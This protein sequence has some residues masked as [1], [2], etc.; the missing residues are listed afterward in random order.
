MPCCAQYSV[1][2]FLRSQVMVH[3]IQEIN[4]RTPR[5][6]PGLTLGYDI[7]D[8]CGDV[9]YAIRAALE[10]L[11]KEPDT[12]T[13]LLPSKFYSAMP[14]PRAKVVIGERYSEVSIAVARIFTLSSVPQISYA[15][16]SELLSKKFKFP[17]FLRTVSSDKFQTK[18]ISTMI[19]SFN[20]KTVAIIGSDDEYGKYGSDSLD[21]TLRGMQVCIE[22]VEILSGDFTRT[23]SKL[24]ELK[25]K[26]EKS[27]AEAIILFTKDANVEV[28]M[29]LAIERNLNRT[30]I[31]SDTWSTSDRI[32][33]L[34]NIQ[35]AGQVFGFIFKR[36]EVPGFKAH[37]TSM[38][39]NGINAIIQNHMTR[40]PLCSDQSEEETARNCSGE[41]LDPLCLASFI[42]QDESYSIYLAVQV[43]AEGLRQL[44]KCDSQRC[45]RNTNFTTSELLEE[46]KKVNFTVNNTQLYFN[47]GDPSLGYDIVYWNTSNKDVKIQTIGEYWPNGSIQ[48][49]E[50]LLQ[51]MNKV[52]V[53]RFNCSKTCNP[54]E[55]LKQTGTKCCT[56]C[57][58]CAAKEFSPGNGTVCKK[59]GDNQHSPDVVRDRCLNNTDD[60]LQW[61]DPFS[62]ILSCWAVCAIIVT[63]V[64]T[65]VFFHFRATPIVKAV[66]GYLCFLELV[67]LLSGFCL[68]FTFLGKPQT[69]SS[70]VGLPLFGMSFCVCISCILANLLQIWVGFKFDLEARSWVKRLNQPLAIVLVSSGIQL[71]LSV[72]WLTVTPPVLTKNPE[73]RTTLH[74]CDI[75]SEGFFFSVIAYDAF[76]AILCFL[77]AIK[78]KKLP[79][80]YKNAELVT[81]AMV[82]FLIIW[83]IFLPLYVTLR[84]KYTPAIQCAAILISCSSILGCH[85]APKCYIMIFRKELNNEKAITEYIRKHYAQKGIAVVR[86]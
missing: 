70:C 74:Q 46:L 50:A 86:S 63:I 12:Q 51:R 22:F 77:F 85:L 79:D 68:V 57:F 20:W 49:P 67:S 35:R 44:L 38:F 52:D 5:V 78:S 1:Q 59:C 48:L 27:V 28:I 81:V 19:K 47:D 33:R 30:W 37:V 4:R 75:V 83:I 11:E 26:L 62:I 61:W 80:L 15:S 42:D 16:T 9:S 76:V 53:T 24:P 31:A 2:M 43:V 72:S 71:A 64:F 82:L 69:D 10:L 17:T 14:E 34:E 65:V 7:Y 18:G 60:F 66:G 41:C 39:D 56:Q 25:S 58:R 8:T 21:E 23:N 3:A 54:G 13:C 6:L 84:G 32:F 55:M 29:E 36:N 45:E 73:E 40:Y